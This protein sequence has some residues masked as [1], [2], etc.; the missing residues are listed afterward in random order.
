MI[1]GE[2]MKT[3]KKEIPIFTACDDNYMPFLAVTLQS[4]IEN[5]AQDY[6][7]SFRILHSGVSSD[8]IQKIMNYNRGNFKIEFVDVRNALKDVMQRLHTCIYYTQTTYYRLFISNLYPQYDKVI[9]IDSDVVVRG[10]ISELYNIEI[11]NNLVG[12]VTDDYVMTHPY[13]QPYF[14]E[15]LGMK[16]VK[17]YFNAG[18]I[19][20][21]LNQFREQKFEDQIVD[22][23]NKYK[24]VVQDQDYLNLICQGKV[25]YIDP[26][27]NKS[28]CTPDV[29]V[30]D[31]KLIHY[32]LIWKPWHADISYGDEFWKYVEKTEYNDIIKNIRA[33]YTEAQYQKDIDGYNDFMDAIHNELFNPENYYHLYLKGK[34]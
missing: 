8:N 17:D 30:E 7:Y 31:I 1:K 10:D 6:I 4:I 3:I 13:I 24:F 21:N 12:A 20:M 34:K 9:Y 16:S 32:K 14:T 2:I 5:A 22:L 15:V 33:N 18:L 26:M 27:W 28:P 19:I 29:K 11:G 23:L 25:K